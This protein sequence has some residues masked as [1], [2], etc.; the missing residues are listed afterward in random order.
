MC[1]MHHSRNTPMHMS[2]QLCLTTTMH[3]TSAKE[4]ILIEPLLSA[5]FGG[6][7]PPLLNAHLV[8]G[9]RLL[10]GALPTMYSLYYI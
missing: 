7:S 8:G 1:S 2:T 9:A 5:S 4:H 6:W 3:S 10:G